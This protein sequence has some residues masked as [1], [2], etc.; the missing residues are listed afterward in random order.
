MQR[1]G[2]GYSA[3]EKQVTGQICLRQL[4]EARSVLWTLQGDSLPNTIDYIRH[5]S[6]PSTVR[7]QYVLYLSIFATFGPNGQPFRAGSRRRAM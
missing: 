7:A 3:T 2:L 4:G 5:L 1:S 6:T